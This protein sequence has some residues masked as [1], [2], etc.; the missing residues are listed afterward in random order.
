[1]LLKPLLVLRVGDLGAVI[2]VESQAPCDR[3]RRGG[4]AVVDMIVGM[5]IAF[6]G[7]FEILP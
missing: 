3:R 6:V 7:L 2:I 4:G 1:M 5:A